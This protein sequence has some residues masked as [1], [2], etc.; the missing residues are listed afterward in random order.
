MTP[1]CHD[2]WWHRSMKFSL[3]L[4]SRL[5]GLLLTGVAKVTPLTQIRQ[6][7][8][9]R[10]QFSKGAPQFL[11]AMTNYWLTSSTKRMGLTSK[12]AW[13]QITG[14]S[15]KPGEVSKLAT[16]MTK[17]RTREVKGQWHHFVM[18]YDGIDRWSSL[19]LS[20]HW[21]HCKHT[22]SVHQSISQV[23]SA[24]ETRRGLSFSNLDD[25]GKE[26]QGKWK[27]NDYHRT[28]LGMKATL[29]N[30]F[31]QQCDW[32]IKYC[33]WKNPAPSM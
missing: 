27:A 33:W 14:S 12:R 18:T 31:S 26:G 6:G 32:F 3:S 1:L 22:T 15:E 16:W 24:L 4:L 17:G 2:L 8:T 9:V 19:S 23:L 7:T 5:S 11:R 28:P 10:K 30:N 13:F 20:A 21:W 29:H 25:Q